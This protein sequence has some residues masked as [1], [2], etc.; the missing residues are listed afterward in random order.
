MR[1]LE[2]WGHSVTVAG[3]GRKAVEA[4]QHSDFDVILMDVQ[5]PEMSGLEATQEIRRRTDNPKSRVPIIAM[6]AHALAG[7]REKCLSSGMDH[8]V[9]KP[10][11]QIQLFDAVESFANGD[12]PPS[13]APEPIARKTPLH[14]DPVLLLQR[15]DGDFELLKEVTQIFMEDTP[16]QLDAVRAALTRNDG[17]AL[18]RAAHATKGALGNFGARD[19]YEAALELEAMGHACDFDRAHARFAALEYQISLLNPALE[20]FLKEKAA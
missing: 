20:A 5:M 14:F 6:T 1:L 7:D 19:A 3:D 8:Y 18:E 11:D 10:I 9:T 2:K 17:P 12:A 16:R 15:M 4:W 13:A